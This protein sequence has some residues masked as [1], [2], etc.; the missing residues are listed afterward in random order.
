MNINIK[1]LSDYPQALHLNTPHGT[2]ILQFTCFQDIP[3][4]THCFTTRMGGTSN[5]IYESMNFKEDGDDLN[6]NIRANYRIIAQALDADVTKMVRPSLVHGT[7]VHEVTAEDFG[8]GA[9]YKSTLTGIDALITDIPGVTLVAT[10]A[11]CV[12]L[13]FVDTR[14]RAIGLAHSGWKGSCHK[15]ALSVLD[16]MRSVYGTEPG[17]ILAAIGPC[18]CGDCYEVGEE[19]D[20]AFQKGFAGKVEGQ[21]GIRYWETIMRPGKREGKYQLDLRQANLQTF[22][23]AGIPRE[24]ITIADICTCCNPQLIFSHRATNGKRGASAAFLGLK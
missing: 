15:I 2:P 6:E 14:H 23:A 19:L 5:G 3:F 11:D 9:L 20:A 1:R 8:V 12:P 22:L 4:I 13:Y 21:T 18:I 16:A 10:F 24:R 17:D 7:V